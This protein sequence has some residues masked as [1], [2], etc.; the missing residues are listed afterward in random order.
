MYLYRILMSLLWSLKER[1][2]EDSCRSQ[3]SVV[4]LLA[5]MVV[6][7]IRAL[8]AFF[9]FFASQDLGDCNPTSS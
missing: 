4:M 9:G 8:I 5:S 3:S 7:V 6:R 2:V 1:S